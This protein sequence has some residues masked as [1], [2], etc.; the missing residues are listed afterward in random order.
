MYE[1]RLL[2]G[3]TVLALKGIL[4]SKHGVGAPS[5]QRLI[6][7]GRVLSDD[8]LTIGEVGIKDGEFVVLMSAAPKS[9]GAA[10]STPARLCFSRSLDG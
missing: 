7:Q 4:E 9:G 1:P 10:A 6:Y 3:S 8:T 2:Q 5:T